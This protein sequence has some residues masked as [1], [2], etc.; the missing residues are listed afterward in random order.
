MNTK[1]ISNEEKNNEFLADVSCRIFKVSGWL[2]PRGFDKRIYEIKVKETEKS[3][4]SD[5]KRISK[6]KLMKVDTIF[7]ETH[8]S[9]RYF[10]YCKDG[11][12]QNAL[13]LI[14]Q[15]IIN[16]VKI[17]KAEIDILMQYVL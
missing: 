4:I 7:I 15:H 2:D 10:T 13:D 3:F 11:E 1:N 14:K 17:Y 9:I 16:K 5:E 6:D 12:Q 8:K